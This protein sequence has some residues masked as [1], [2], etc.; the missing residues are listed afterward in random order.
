MAQY[1][2]FVDLGSS[3]TKAVMSDGVSLQAFKCS[4]LVADMP[5]SE[6]AIVE[7]QGEQLGTG[8]ESVSYIQLDPED[9][10]YALGVDAQGKPNKSTSNLPKSALA[11]LKVLGVIGEL[12]HRYDLTRVPLDVG[13]ALPFNEYLTDYK[14]LTN[15]LLAQKSFTYRGRDIDLDLAQVK[16][17]PEAAGLVQWRKVEI[18][19][20]GGLSNQT[21]AVLMFGH[22]DLSFLF[23]REGK[24]PRGEP[25]STERLGFQQVLV[26]ISQDLP[27]NSDDPFLYEAL[28]KGMGSVTFPARPG[29]VYRLSDRFEQAKA[30]Y[31]DLVKHRL[32]EWFA[33]VDVPHYEVLISGGVAALLMAELED[34]F[35]A[36]AA[37]CTVNWLDH[38]KEEVGGALNL[39]SEIEQIRFSDCYGGAKWMALKFQK[40]VKAGG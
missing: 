35:E 32:D 30:Y 20:H 27:C 26:A 8:L 40:P 9:P 33:A 37:F 16:V 38:L 39:A 5:P 17:L 21:F 34:Y 19:Q 3:S 31:W 6:L 14:P 2:C 25:S 13:V 15:R 24:P 12:A 29:Q 11:H 28:I 22:R 36:R 7:A 10:V 4:P 18:A 1:Q 23:F